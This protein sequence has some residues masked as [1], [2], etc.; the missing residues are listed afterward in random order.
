M[1]LI[2]FPRLASFGRT[3]FRGKRLEK[4]LDDE[5]R[6]YLEELT[7]RKIGEGLD[8]ATARRE[9]L[10]EMGGV[11]PVKE[12]ARDARI[13]VGV[14][15]TLRDARYAWRSLRKSPGFALATVLTLGLGIGASTAIFSVVDAMLLS[16]LPDRDSSR[17][18]FVWSDMTEAGYPRAPLSG[19]E[20]GDLRSRATLFEGFG[21]IW[22][23]S[24][25]LT[26]DGEPQRLR[27]GFVTTDFFTVLGAG[28]TAVLMPK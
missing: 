5:V 25:A 28:G 15:T 24:A 10:L 1:P 22:A 14:E 16:P 23:N 9:A 11:E 12:E 8:P 26:G 27:V 2:R 21:A 13:G 6:G 20:L 19:P 3:L 7:R 18:A 4:D 17:L